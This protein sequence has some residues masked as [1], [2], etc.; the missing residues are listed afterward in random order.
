MGIFLEKKISHK[1]R[2]ER[3]DHD[4][5]P[6]QYRRERY[7]LDIYQYNIDNTDMTSRPYWLRPIRDQ[8]E[9]NGKKMDDSR[10]DDSKI[11]RAHV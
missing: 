4:I 8:Y 9:K 11:G 10:D 2:R 5:L 7:D 1:Y 6:I 3:Y